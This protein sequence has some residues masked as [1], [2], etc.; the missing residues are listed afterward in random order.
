[1]R[2]EDLDGYVLPLVLARVHRGKRAL[3]EKKGRPSGG[4]NKPTVR[5]VATAAV[6]LVCLHPRRAPTTAR[7]FTSF[8][9]ISDDGSRTGAFPGS[10][11]ISE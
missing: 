9:V 7:R 8:N 2:K 11:A 4:F 6:P 10:C 5:V 3:R 1:M